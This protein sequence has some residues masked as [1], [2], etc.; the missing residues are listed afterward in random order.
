M[1]CPQWV[2]KTVDNDGGSS[3]RAGLLGYLRPGRKA[4]GKKVDAGRGP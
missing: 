1:T 3:S 4:R 2:R